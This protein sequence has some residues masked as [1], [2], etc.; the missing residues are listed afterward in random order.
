MKLIII[1][2]TYACE[3]SKNTKKSDCLQSFSAL[4]AA[5][6]LFLF[7]SWR[8]TQ[9]NIIFFDPHLDLAHQNQMTAEISSGI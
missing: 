8:R 3:I 5:C 9:V 2:I 6:I 1:T 4:C 7:Y